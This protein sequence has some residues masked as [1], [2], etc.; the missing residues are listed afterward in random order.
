MSQGFV[1]QYAAEAALRTEGVARLTASV[2]VVLKE[3]LGFVHEGKG[4]LVQFSENEEGFVS[5]TVYP[6][7]YY[8]MIIPEVAWA[9]QERVKEDVEK[10]TGLVVESVNVHVCGVVLREENNS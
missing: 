7:V 4:V 9:I 8:G 10:Y 1:A 2:P 6:V 3:S 5:V